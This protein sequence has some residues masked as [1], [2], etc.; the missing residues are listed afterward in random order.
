LQAFFGNGRAL[1]KSSR[2]SGGLTFNPNGE[3][4]SFSVLKAS[5]PAHLRPRREKIFGDGRP[6]GL[7]RNAKVRIM[8]RA[9]ALVRKTEKGKHYGIITAKMLD[10]L[11]A[12]LWVF[13]N[14]RSGLCF[15]S[16]E[17]IAKAAGCARSTV[18]EAIKALEDAGL[19]TWVNR[20][21][22]VR[23][24][25]EDLFGHMGL[26]WRILRTSNGYQF[27]DPLPGGGVQTAGLV[28]NSSKSE[29]RSGTSNQDSI[30]SLLPP[31]PPQIDPNTELGAALLNFQRAMKLKEATN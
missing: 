10:V 1:P 23:E 20:I 8:H 15:P 28:G 21:V 29:F 4:M 24:R 14:G 11:K 27:R 12:L 6:R 22:R 26:R 3:A 13:H 7:D 19:L 9:A 31:A 18:A 17:A 2:L 30:S 16:Y 25:C 5:L